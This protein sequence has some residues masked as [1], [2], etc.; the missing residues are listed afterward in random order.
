M[1]NETIPETSFINKVKIEN[2]V[3]ESDGE[4]DDNNTI[5]NICVIAV[6]GTKRSDPAVVTNISIKPKGRYNICIYVC[7]TNQ[8]T[9]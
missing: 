5:F 1:F 2:N 9:I 8:V 3:S 6:D 4:L 7:I